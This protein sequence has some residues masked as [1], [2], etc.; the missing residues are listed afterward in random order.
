MPRTT[1][2]R[3]RRVLLLTDSYRPTVNG[4]VTSIDELRKGLVEAGH[5]VRVLTVGPTRRTTFDGEVYRLPSLDA[6]HIYPHARLGRPVDRD[7]WADLVAWR[8]EVLHSHTEF[9]AFWW[10]RR[11]A[12]RL[13]VPHLHTYHTLYADY[14]HYFFPH[15]RTGR[16]LV[17]RFARKTLNRTDLVIAP[18]AKIETLL[19]GYGVRAPVCVVPTGIDLTRFTPGPGS[20]DLRASLDLT[21]GVPVVLSLGR[22][23]AE[24]NTAEVIDLLA[25]VHE[26]WQLVVA[27]DGPQAGALRRQVER[28]GLTPRVRFVGAIEPARVPDFY[29]LADV[30][31]SVS[32]SETQGLTY[33]EALA[34]GIPVLCRDDASV[35]GVVVDDVNGRTYTTPEEFTRTLTDLLRDPDL[36]ERWSEGAV[37]SAARSGRDTFAAAVGAAYDRAIS[38]AG[39]ARWAA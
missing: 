28:L 7:L 1:A 26:P 27:G 36:R 5:E 16:A 2:A 25:T 30:F 3:A 19:R 33:L 12:H 39:T 18:T 24:K 9:V 6:S 17:A 22:L 8:P 14:T 37:R 20:E 13:D 34:S 11:L 10:A 21:P 23:A 35:D 4:V 31:V 32:R 15:E 38:A 29:R